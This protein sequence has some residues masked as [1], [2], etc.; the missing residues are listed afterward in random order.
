VGREGPIVQIGS[1]IGSTLGQILR[2]S[3]SHLRTM[4]GC[5][6]AAGIAATFNAPVAGVL[7]ALEVILG[8]FGVRRFT[9]IVISSVI[10]TA[11]SHSL[12]GDVPAFEI[13]VDYHM[14]SPFEL[15]SYSVLGVAA[16]IVAVLFSR[17]V[18]F[19]EDAFDR[20]KLPALVKPVVGGLLIG[21]IGLKFPHIFGVGYE[22][23]EMA[24]NAELAWNF[25]LLLVG[26]KLLATSLTLGSGGS[27]GIF[28]PSLF[29]GAVLGGALGHQFHTLFPTLTASSGAY[30]LVGMGAVV[31]AAT[32]APLTSIMI[33]FEMTG[34]YKIILPLMFACIIGNVIAI[35]LSDQSIYTMKLFRRGVN[36]LRGQDVNVLASLKVKSILSS[37]YTTIQENTPL[38]KIL[39]QMVKHPYA[40]FYVT[41]DE[42]CFKGV[43]AVD[44]FRHVIMDSGAIQD[45]VIAKDVMAETVP[46]INKDDTLDKVMFLFGSRNREEFPVIDPGDGNRLL[47]VITRQAL[48]STY[49]NELM[50]RDAVKEVALGVSSAE[51]KEPVH[52]AR[53]VAL[54]EVEAPGWM[55]GKTL[56]SLDLRKNRGVQVLMINPGDEGSPSGQPSIPSPDTVIELGDNLLV[57][58]STEAIEGLKR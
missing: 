14:V 20:I 34:D 1:A 30:A 42:G 52:L 23:I 16:G 25:L 13:A 33:I 9:P 37:K 19:S 53:G 56:V 35:R 7:F 50:K 10:A 49:N 21:G 6:A 46:L 41:D 26:I 31:A 36:L 57:L 55:V 2:V 4:V 28:A 22:T 32:R 58:G 47:G 39:Q 40:Y 3:R 11:M 48:I 17:M 8:D 43:V 45:L 12:V 18:Y 38:G 5:G 51:E 24:L 27:G 29:L 15:L 54:A 44:D